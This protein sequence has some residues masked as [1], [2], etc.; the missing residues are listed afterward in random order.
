MLACIATGSGLIALVWLT[1]GIDAVGTAAI[2]AVVLVA[3]LIWK[4]THHWRSAATETAETSE[5]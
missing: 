5:N 1:D 3:E 2:V 4:H